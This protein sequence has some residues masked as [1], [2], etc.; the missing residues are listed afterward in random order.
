MPVDGVNT[1]YNPFR[2]TE[3]YQKVNNQAKINAVAA[4]ANVNNTDV[5]NN[6]VNTTAENTVTA[7]TNEN[8]T[9]NTNTKKTVQNETYTNQVQRSQTQAAN[10]VT[11][12]QKT[13]N[14][15]DVIAQAMTQANKGINRLI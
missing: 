6:V 10:F 14:G 7:A 13:T 2:L 5:T 9:T 15:M 12:A 4:Q 3:N 1:T 8:N 11:N